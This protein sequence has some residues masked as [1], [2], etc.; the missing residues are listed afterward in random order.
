[1]AIKTDENGIPV[2]E[3]KESLRPVTRKQDTG[4]REN[5]K[6]DSFGAFPEQSAVKNKRWKGGD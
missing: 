4:A 6:R 1:M 3:H 5:T 2:N